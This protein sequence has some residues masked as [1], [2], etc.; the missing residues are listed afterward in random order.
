MDFYIMNIQGNS[1]EEI[2]IA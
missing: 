2:N 1:I